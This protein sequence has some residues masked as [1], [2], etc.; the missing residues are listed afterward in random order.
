MKINVIG[1]AGLNHSYAHVMDAYVKGL[2][3]AQLF[4]T[5]EQPFSKTWKRARGSI[6]DTFPD[7]T[8]EQVDIAIR[9]SYPY[10]IKSDR[11]AKRTLVF[12]TCEFNGLSDHVDPLDLP[13][14]VFI[15]TP[16]LYSKKGIVSSGFDEKKIF[17]VHHCFDGPFTCGHVREKL[18]LVDKFVFFHNSSLTS[19]KNGQVIIECFLK[20]CE[21]HPNIRL[22]IKGVDNV[23]NTRNKLDEI[24]Q[25][26]H[27]SH[28]DK[29]VY[30]GNDVSQ[31]DMSR[32]YNS[33][34]CYV[35]PFLAEGFNLPVLE[36]LCH[37]IPVIC[38]QGGPP[39]EF[40]ENAHF[41]PSE[42]G[43]ALPN[44]TRCGNDIDKYAMYPNADTFQMMMQDMLDDANLFNP[45][46]YREKYSSVVIGKQLLNVCQTILDTPVTIPRVWVADSNQIQNMSLYSNYYL[47]TKANARIIIHSPILVM[48]D[49]TAIYHHFTAS[50]DFYYKSSLMMQLIKPNTHTCKMQLVGLQEIA[51]VKHRYIDRANV[52]LLYLHNGSKYTR[53]PFLVNDTDK[54][55]QDICVCRKNPQHVILEECDVAVI[56]ADVFEKYKPIY[57]KA[58][59][60]VLYDKRMPLANTNELLGKKKIFVYPEALTF[61]AKCILPRL[62][63]SFVLYLYDESKPIVAQLSITIPTYYASEQ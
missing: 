16:S 45:N 27:S 43:I 24:F 63:H 6:V 56:T 5:P 29:V 46:Y 42:R 3:T 36:A 59:V 49:L 23:Y 41:I 26:M 4:F 51:N 7:G 17:V 9:F 52:K 1:W 53:I 57:R 61:F 20:L 58:I 19:N 54:S 22:L 50:V 32:L 37:G 11:N 47:D 21:T 12:M 31:D 39:D 38:T 35:S 62:K 55:V 60:T 33:S 44:I 25:S 48:S 28:I 10:N 30:V 40:A 2:S 14:D 8:N 18:G 34:N 15:L 13:D